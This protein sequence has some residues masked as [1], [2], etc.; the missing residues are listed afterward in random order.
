MPA[1]K[2][3]GVVVLM[4]R[5]DRTYYPTDEGVDRQTAL[6]NLDIVIVL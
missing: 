5:S 2:A 4:E 6:S 3:T 1:T